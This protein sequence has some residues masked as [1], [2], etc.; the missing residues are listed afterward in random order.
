MNKKIISIFLLTT[1]VST[2]IGTITFAKELTYAT[3][4]KISSKNKLDENDSVVN[5]PDNNLK[6]ALNKKLGKPASNIITKEQLKSLTGT[7]DLTYK[8]ISNLEGIQY[9]TNLNWLCLNNNLL[10][11][12]T[13]L[14]NLTNLTG[15]TLDGNSIN[16]I[17]PL[18]KLTNLTHLY[19]D[20]TNI[21]DITPLSNLTNLT[22]LSLEDNKITDVSSLTNLKNLTFLDLENNQIN[23]ISPLVNLTNLRTLELNNQSIIGKDVTSIGN[24]AIV[25]NIIKD[26]NS[27]LI[28][29]INNDSYSYDSNNGQIT[30]NDIS[31]TGNKYYE[32]STKITLGKATS[33]FNGKVKQNIMFNKVNEFDSKFREAYWNNN[34]L[35]FGG[36]FDILGTEKDKNSKKILLIKDENDNIIKKIDTWNAS[37]N[38]NTGYQCFIDKNTLKKLKDGK[39]TLFVTTV[40]DGVTYES[41]IK[42][43]NKSTENDINSLEPL[44]FDESIIKFFTDVNN[45]VVFS[46]N[47]SIITPNSNVKSIY[48]NENGLV[49]D[50]N[51]GFKEVSITNPINVKLIIK[52]SNGST[53]DTINTWNASWGEKNTGFQGI[54]GKDI[55]SE[56]E[57]NEYTLF[58]STNFNGKEF[59]TKLVANSDFNIGNTINDFN[60]SVKANK[61]IIT[62]T[63]K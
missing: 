29:P 52:N 25:N 49:I 57:K 61:D 4:N 58:A 30:F 34:S 31:V 17:S 21:Q 3:E 2:Q 16:D 43:S 5:I 8:F 13:P 63:K 42:T 26:L 38:E 53:I 59:E 55:L 10:K 18:S 19:V 54:I 32:F 28:A 45:D 44:R 33:V 37:W 60:I 23:D 35:V 14:S 39:Y 48:F 1:I 50:G 9:C 11:D 40:I 12:I 7:L 36:T 47:E 22:L 20:Y 46:K 51:L 15:L 62:L 41:T 56:L 27:D 6:E 24:K